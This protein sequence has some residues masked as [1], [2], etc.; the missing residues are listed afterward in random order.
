MLIPRKTK[1]LVYRHLFQEGVMCC[2]DDA[3]APHHHE[4][5]SIPNLHV[6]KLLQSL[7]SRTL[8]NRRYNWRWNYYF[9][10][11]SGVAYLREYLGSIPENVAPKTHVKQAGRPQSSRPEGERRF[12]GDRER[13]DR[14]RFGGDRERSEFRRGPPREGGRGFAPKEGG[15]PGG[16]AQPQFRGSAGRGFGRGRAAPQ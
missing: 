14:G 10:T 5:K 2:K 8:V 13:G 1:N 7:A 6:M 3:N 16:D 9:L 15:A 12:G 11:D 4:L